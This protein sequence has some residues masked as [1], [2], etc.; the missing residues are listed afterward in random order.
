[1]KTMTCEDLGGP[2]KEAFHGE[3]PDDVI[4]AAEKHLHE[5]VEKGDEA[6][7]PAVEMM[8]KIRSNPASGMDW[9]QKTQRDFA[10]LPED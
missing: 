6:H 3:T 5:M 8:N 9:Y 10:A 1:M 4:K 2:C 7:K